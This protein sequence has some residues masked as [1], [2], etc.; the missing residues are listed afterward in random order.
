MAVYDSD[1]QVLPMEEVIRRAMLANAVQQAT[2]ASKL[3]APETSRGG[4]FHRRS[5]RKSD[6]DDRKEEA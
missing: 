2:D 4:S 5:T 3:L 6:E 1:D